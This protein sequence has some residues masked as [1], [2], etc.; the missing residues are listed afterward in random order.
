MDALIEELRQMDAV[1]VVRCKECKYFLGDEKDPSGMCRETATYNPSN[2]F[3][4]GGEKREG[5][6]D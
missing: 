1:P 6:D 2:W 4:A 5:D 3:C